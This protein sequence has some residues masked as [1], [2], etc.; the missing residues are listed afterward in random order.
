[1]GKKKILFMPGHSR[2]VFKHGMVGEVAKRLLDNEDYE[3][4]YLDCNNAIKTPCGLHTTR[5]LFY[6]K[7]CVGKCIALSKM[8]GLK[9][10]NILKMQKYK[11]PKFP[12]FDTIQNLIDFDYEGYNYGLS[13][14]SC[15]MSLTRDYAFDIKKWQ[16][17]IKKYL[18]T[19]YII[20]KNLERLYAEYKFDEIHT[21]N[22]RMTSMY[23]CVS[24][25]KKHNIPYVVYERG[26]NLNKLR[27]IYND[28][29]HNF[30]NTKKDIAEYWAKA[31][32]NKNELA[33]KWF[34]ERRAGKYQAIG[35]FTKD[36]IKDLLPK[37]YD[38]DKTN[39]V[40]FNSSIDE[41]YAFDSW[42]HPFANSENEVL[43]QLFE[44]YKDDSS[45]HFYLR[46]HPNLTPAKKN[47]TTQI[48]EL[49]ALKGKYNNVTIIEPDEKIDTYAMIDAADKVLTTYSTAGCEATFWG[50]TAI[51]GGKTVYEDLD[52]AY[53]ASSLEEI[54][55]LLDD[56][57]L[58]PKPKESAYPLGYYYQV[59]GDEYK[60]FKAETH[61]KGTFMGL[62]LDEK[63]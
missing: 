13:P 29:P 33:E 42:K 53:K 47:K 20:F 7:K 41:V 38:F 31:P 44:H 17:F 30:Y 10:E 62:L 22:G 48:R 55:K 49:D 37:N 52:C 54:I 39:I 8:C 15:V 16:K 59:Y 2:S 45:K 34:N 61:H 26:S 35:S 32:D 51:F 43:A 6:C 24:F 50:T 46:I 1:M 57:S 58:Q 56:D 60:F 25:A 21:F 36:Q 3:V 5:S 4:Y 23:P 14:A 27:T 40:I 63:R 19:E 11:A 18:T 9:D 28:V 12:D